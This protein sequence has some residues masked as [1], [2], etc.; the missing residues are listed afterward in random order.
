MAFNT[1]SREKLLL[2]ILKCKEDL[3]KH[4]EF[5][6]LILNYIGDIYKLNSDTYTDIVRFWD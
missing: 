4:K 5:M 2:S 6:K 1:F 3:R